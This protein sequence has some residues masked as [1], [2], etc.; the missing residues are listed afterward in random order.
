MVLEAVQMTLA[1]EEQDENDRHSIA[2]YGQ[3]MAEGG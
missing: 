3:K 1:S 2:L